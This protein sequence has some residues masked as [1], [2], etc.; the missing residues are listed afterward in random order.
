MVPKKD[1]TPSLLF[2]TK[3]RRT[4][5]LAITVLFACLFS[6]YSFTQ[7]TLDHSTEQGLSPQQ[8]SE[9]AILHY[10][11]H[12]LL[13]EPKSPTPKNFYPQKNTHS[14]QTSKDNFIQLSIFK[15][16]QASLNLAVL[17]TLNKMSPLIVYDIM[18]NVN[19]P[20]RQ[21]KVKYTNVHRRIKD[22]L[23]KGYVEV[24]GWRE[25]QPGFRSTL[26]QPTTKARLAYMLCKVDPE[27]LVNESPEDVQVTEMAAL[28]MFFTE[29]DQSPLSK[30]I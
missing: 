9:N 26:Y 23:K 28:T 7:E 18:K 8:G 29:T 13:A 20:R 5:W 15:G 16:R 11:P 12:F 1:T 24:A 30:R 6:L 21:R 17:Q 4:V 10:S 22:L 19:A 25:T 3:K 2:T 27:K 14:N